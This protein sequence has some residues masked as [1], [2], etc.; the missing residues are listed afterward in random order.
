MQKKNLSFQKNPTDVLKKKFDEYKN[1]KLIFFNSTVFNVGKNYNWLTN[2]DTGYVYDA[3][4]HW[5]EILD[6]SKEAG[7]IKYVWEKS[8]FCFFYDI[9]RY[10][11]HFNED[12]SQIVF[13]EIL[14]WIKNNPINSGPNY[15]CSQETSLR[16]LNWTFALHYYKNS[17]SLTS[18]IFDAIQFSIYWQIHHVYN[19][20][21]FSRIAVR[22]NHAITE[23]LS[24]YLIGLLYPQF[25]N[26]LRWKEK[27]KAWFEKEIAYQVYEDGTY[28]QFSMNYHRVVIQLMT[29]AIILSEKNNEKF[30]D[31]VYERAKK[32]LTF[33]CVCMNDSNG[34]LPNYGANDGALF[35]P[36]NDEH[37]RNYKPQ[38][39][40]LANALHIDTGF[41]KKYEDIN[42]Y[43][44]HLTN[45]SLPIHNGIYQFKAGGYY[46]IREKDTLTFIRCGSYKDRPSQADNLHLDI[47]YKGENIIA[48]AGSYKYNTD[49]TTIKYFAGT[50]SHNTVILNNYDQMQK[51]SRF[52]WYYWSQCL[53]AHL[54]EESDV[55]KFTGEI[56]AFSYIQK[57]IKHKREIT[58]IKN[59]PQW[60]IKDEII[61]MPANIVLKQLWH[62][63]QHHKPVEWESYNERN[64]MLNAKFETGFISN[65]YGQ[66]E[67]SE[68]IIFQTPGFFIRTLLSIKA[69][70]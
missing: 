27:G 51:G 67:I 19:N 49:E 24:L 58:K 46:I 70:E 44:Q 60:F 61:N 36:L 13:D 31:V 18:E 17:S 50:A 62:L 32:S 37:F 10:D 38:L 69:T 33:L 53:H 48:D 52:I 59:K 64:E 12:C 66:K 6:Y 3:N 35:F 45:T 29:W 7:D 1:G 55:Y 56:A 20:I 30:S 22:N 2:P 4:K 65:L 5:T 68:N 8:R 42:W 23:T 43:N 16:I 54:M 14:S 28:L 40:S 57:G 41:D 63:P 21:Q 39:Q 9:I 34:W 26:A 47:W 15:V 25:P 11:Y